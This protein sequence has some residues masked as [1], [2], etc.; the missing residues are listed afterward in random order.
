A[1][2]AHL[3]ERGLRPLVLEK[4]ARVGTTLLEWGHVQVFSPWRYNID[5]AARRLLTKTSWRAPDPDAMP[6]GAEIVRDYLAPLAAVPAIA[7]ALKLGAQVT[8]ITR[9]GRDKLSD[10]GRGDAPLVIRYV[11]TGGEQR[12]LARAVIDASGT[13]SRPNPLG[14]DGLPV[15]GEAALANRI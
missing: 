5:E 7:S 3:V 15:P 12:V 11:D 2:A 10:E 13:W 6:T 1:A 14:I 8:A 9:L 4:G